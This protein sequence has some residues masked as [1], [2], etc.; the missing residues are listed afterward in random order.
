MLKAP[1][2]FIHVVVG[3]F[4]VIT[5]VLDYKRFASIRKFFSFL[6]IPGGSGGTVF[7]YFPSLPNRMEK[8]SPLRK[9]RYVISLKN[10]ETGSRTFAYGDL[11]P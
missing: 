11:T 4:T 3:L 7:I 1:S 6:E 5:R 2:C 9:L 10:S 8:Y